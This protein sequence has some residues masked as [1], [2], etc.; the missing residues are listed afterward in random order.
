MT[1]TSHRYDIRKRRQAGHTEEES[2]LE[3]GR[4][5]HW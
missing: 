4:L 3:P 5:S 1:M 2:R